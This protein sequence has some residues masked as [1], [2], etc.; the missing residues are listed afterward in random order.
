MVYLLTLCNIELAPP[1]LHR[2]NI[3]FWFSLVILVSPNNYNWLF[4]NQPNYSRKND[5]NQ[6]SKFNFK[7]LFRAKSVIFCDQG[8]TLNI[9]YLL[10]SGVSKYNKSWSS[11]NQSW[12][13]ASLERQMVHKV[14]LSWHYTIRSVI[15]TENLLIRLLQKF[16]PIL[17]SSDTIFQ[18]DFCKIYLFS[19]F[20]SYFEVKMIHC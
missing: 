9:H 5:D 3:F 16:P 11:D 6:N 7:R 19:I 20:F 8:F 2:V 15:K 18:F 13:T 4:T 1:K 17:I 10:H 12:R 14:F